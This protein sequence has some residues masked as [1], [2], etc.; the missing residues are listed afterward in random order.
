MSRDD[1][2]DERR[3]SQIANVIE[4]NQAK[5]IRYAQS[6]LKDHERAKDVVQETFIRLCKTRWAEV[7]EHLQPWLFRVTRNLALDTLRKEKRMSY[8]EEPEMLTRL[9]ETSEETQ[10]ESARKQDAHSLLELAKALPDRQS[11]VVLLKFQQDLSY[12]EIS[13]VTGLSVTNVG[14]LL[15]HALRELK[16]R[17]HAGQTR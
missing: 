5:L 12:K 14:Y 1:A 10:R 15:H 7:E 17:W 6:I 4:T 3:C 16:S 2:S 9:N 8:L 13:E 11:E